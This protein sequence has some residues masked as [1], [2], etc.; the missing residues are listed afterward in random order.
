MGFPSQVPVASEPYGGLDLV[1]VDV[2]VLVGDMHLTIRACCDSRC[3]ECQPE[4][5]P[6]AD[7]E[8]YL[9][10]DHNL[11][12]GIEWR[13]QGDTARLWKRGKKLYSGAGLMIRVEL[14]QSVL[15]LMTQIVL[16]RDD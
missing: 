15:R 9:L 6:A 13:Y 16:R 1:L 3:I 11:E 7:L 4:G 14:G 10:V 5:M 8:E 12:S 2:L